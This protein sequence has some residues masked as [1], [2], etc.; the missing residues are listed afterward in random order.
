MDLQLRTEERIEELSIAIDYCANA[1]AAKKSQSNANRL[2][3]L[4]KLKMLNVLLLEKV[5]TK[6]KIL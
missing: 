4:E 3:F 2:N 5:S 1:Y 6:E